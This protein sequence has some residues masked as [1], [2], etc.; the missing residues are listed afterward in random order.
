MLGFSGDLIIVTGFLMPK[1]NCTFSLKVFDAVA[2]KAIM[3]T[4]DGIKLRTSFIRKKASLNDV[5]L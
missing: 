1:N 2:V 4:P 3:F 5:P